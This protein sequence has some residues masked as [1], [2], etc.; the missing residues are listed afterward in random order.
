MEQ[1]EVEI[2]QY[3]ISLATQMGIKYGELL[4]S[5]IGNRVNGMMDILGERQSCT[6]ERNSDGSCTLFGQLK[7]KRSVFDYTARGHFDKE[8]I[9]L[10]LKY[11]HGVFRLTGRKTEKSDAANLLANFGS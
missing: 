11:K 5:V 3:A 2:Y 9:L 7:T 1:N 4:L 8:S 6:G 10:D